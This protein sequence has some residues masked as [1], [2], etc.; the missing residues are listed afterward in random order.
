MDIN[1]SQLDL[2]RIRLSRNYP[3]QVQGDGHFNFMVFS[4]NNLAN[5]CFN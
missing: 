2:E 1:F 5:P 4:T 3:W